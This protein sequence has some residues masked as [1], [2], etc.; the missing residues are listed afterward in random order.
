MGCDIHVRTET[1]DQD[2]NWI[3]IDNTNAAFD[4]RSYSK[5]AF[6]AGVRNYSRITPICEPRGLPDDVTE[7]VKHE[8]YSYQSSCEVHT[9]CWL[10]VDELLNFDYTQIIEDFR[11]ATPN[12]KGEIVGAVEPL[13]EYLGEFFFKELSELKQFGA[14]R[15]I[16]WFDN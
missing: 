12:Y 2:G 9:P 3:C 16:F 15:I 4:H 6:I 7:E 1:K 5:F 8:F 10:T 13:S 11:H 14:E